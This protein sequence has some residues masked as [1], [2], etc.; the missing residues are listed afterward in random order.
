MHLRLSAFENINFILIILIEK[1][2]LIF[3]RQV[4]LGSIIS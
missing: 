1:F 2:E 4:L 3:T